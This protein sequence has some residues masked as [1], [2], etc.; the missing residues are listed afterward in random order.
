MSRGSSVIPLSS[1]ASNNSEHETF[2]LLTSS[3]DF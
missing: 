2:S 3:Q 1:V